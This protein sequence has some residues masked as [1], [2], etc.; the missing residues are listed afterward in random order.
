MFAVAFKSQ[1]ERQKGIGRFNVA[2][3][4]MHVLTFRSQERLLAIASS[5]RSINQQV[6]QRFY[7]FPILVAG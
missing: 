3:Y 1:V 2:L 5:G 7:S 6:P 4:Y